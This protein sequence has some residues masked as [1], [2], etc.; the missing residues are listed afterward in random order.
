M[1]REKT[2]E[3]V[4]WL[5]GIILFTVILVV[6]MKYI[7]PVILPFLIAWA[8][9]LAVRSPAKRIA[10]RIR[11]P[12]RIIRLAL[13]IA[14]TA[15]LF[16]V[17][18]LVLWQ[19][20]GALWGILSDIGKGEGL[21][22]ILM[23]ISSPSLPIFGDG[24]PPELAERI[25]EAVRSMLSSTLASL[26]GAVTLWVS[27]VPRAF[28]FL[29]VTLIS[30]VYFNLELER[31]NALVR[32]VLPERAGGLLSKIRHSIFEVGLK[33]VK[34]YL[35]IMLITFGIMLVGFLIIG[36]S[37]APLIALI[38][39]C[40]DILP[41]IGVG[42]VLVPWSIFEFAGGN[43]A[44][45]V[46]LL[47]LFVVNEI[48]RQFSEPKIVG[49]SLDIHPLLTLVL[50]YVGYSLFGISGLILVPIITALLGLIKKNE[51]TEVGK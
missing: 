5:L 1:N 45:A 35:L 51:S 37:R 33:Y 22:E 20:I 46:G 9:A 43:H 30:L 19:L 48:I 41:I 16:G 8:V 24:I 50:L 4:F 14:V 44:V 32:A 27:V 25:S 15:I 3:V 2:Q 6:F 10:E 18:S 42:T 7:L 11:V 21:Y 23:Q 34:S 49:K 47:V 40:L 28:I 12:E 26:A 29:I 13:A 38:V 39:A 17:V 36:V 31:I